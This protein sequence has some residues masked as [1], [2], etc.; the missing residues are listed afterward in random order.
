VAAAII[1]AA[2][3]ASCSKPKQAVVRPPRAVEAVRLSPRNFAL[4]TEYAA[5]ILPSTQINV[6]PK[7]GGKVEEVLAKV[8]DHI[9]KGQVLLMIEPADYDDQL[10][11]AK[12][13]L[14]SAQAQLTRSNDAGQES[15][16][17]Q[18]QSN[19][20][21]ARVQLDEVQKA[22]DK[23]KRLFDGGVVSK[24]QMDELDAKL[25]ASTI[26]MDAA[27]KA[28]TLVR[29]KSG[30]QASDVLS[31]Q[32]EAAQ[33]QTDL[34][35]RQLEATSI[36]SPL[37]G[38]VSY[39]DAEPGAMIGP[40]T[41]VFVIIDD[42]SVLA[43][44]GLTDRAIGFVRPG[45]SLKVL[46]PALGPSGERSGTVDRVAPA[47]DPRTNLYTVRVAIANGDGRIRPGML[48]KIRFP[49]EQRRQALLVPERATF[50]E[51]GLDYV[52]VDSGG[53]AKRRQVGLGESDGSLVEIAEGLEPGDVVVTAGQEFVSEG[54]P[55]KTTI[56]DKVED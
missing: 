53:Q 55:I 44:A 46:I 41:L 52:V 9:E 56:V 33:A 27:E 50:S 25:K 24:Q 31:S 32:V 21:Q 7:V 29:D 1:A 43:E 5:R 4:E 11:Q 26:Q 14:Q 2:A 39:R 54:D 10:R 45:M 18:A 40:Q 3:L 13:A 35:T 48:A 17:L 8:G 37:S 38:H 36:R 28:L 22:W 42:S 47:S 20:D 30:K 16:V 15:Q 51:N 34:A 23:T 49:I 12:A 19:A 6:T